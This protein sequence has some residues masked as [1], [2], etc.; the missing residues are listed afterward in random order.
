MNPYTVRAQQSAALPFTQLTT[1]QR[2]CGVL[3]VWTACGHGSASHNSKQDSCVVDSLLT[4]KAP[5]LSPF[6]SF[7]VRLQL[8]RS[9][10]LLLQVCIQKQDHGL[11]TGLDVFLIPHC[12]PALPD[13]PG[14]LEP[15]PV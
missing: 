7:A 6:L 10:M 4:F 3:T 1:E 13:G 5:P 15:E 12:K 14:T 2:R 8:F 9:C 11:D